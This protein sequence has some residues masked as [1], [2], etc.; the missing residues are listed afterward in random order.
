MQFYSHA[1]ASCDIFIIILHTL[2]DIHINSNLIVF[3]LQTTDI[4]KLKVLLVSMNPTIDILLK[5]SRVP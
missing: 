2:I 1:I 5:T 3:Y 4:S